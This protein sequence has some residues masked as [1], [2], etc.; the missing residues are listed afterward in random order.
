MIA[1]VALAAVCALRSVSDHP[2]SPAMKCIE[3]PVVP[4]AE[5]EPPAPESEPEPEL[6]PRFSWFWNDVWIEDASL[7]ELACAMQ[8]LECPDYVTNVVLAR[9]VDEHFSERERALRTIEAFWL[10]ADAHEKVVLERRRALWLLAA[11]KRSAFSAETGV[12]W[13][14]VQSQKLDDPFERAS[15][16]V[17]VYGHLE[18]EKFARAAAAAHRAE[19]N[20]MELK[21]CYCLTPDHKV[22]LSERRAVLDAYR[23]ELADFLTPEEIREIDFR[24]FRL[25]LFDLWDADQLFGSAPESD[26]LRK[27]IELVTPPDYA[28]YTLV[29]LNPIETLTWRGLKRRNGR[30]WRLLG[31]KT[32]LHF[33]KFTEGRIGSV[34]LWRAR[35]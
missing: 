22:F 18:P 27:V 26:V 19:V 34:V 23:H 25:A 15:F 24:K 10:T 33:R 4:A 20:V 11:E 16:K 21:Q 35:R 6:K 30:L 3:V 31:K 9:A 17:A 5:L 28:A 1:N 12:D 7:D 13:A 29:N 32:Y 2:A 8:E 14:F